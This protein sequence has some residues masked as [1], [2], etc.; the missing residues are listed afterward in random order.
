MAAPKKKAVKTAKQITAVRKAVPA[1]KKVGAKKGGP[2][3]RTT[4]PPA[5]GKKPATAGKDMTRMGP[6]PRP[7]SQSIPFQG[8]GPQ[9][10]GVF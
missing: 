1:V 4:S 3:K 5:K 7:G 2:V 10:S 6:G 8:P 9:G